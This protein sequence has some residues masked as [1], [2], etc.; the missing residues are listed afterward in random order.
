[1]ATPRVRGQLIGIDRQ[2]KKKTD[3]EKVRDELISLSL[4][5]VVSPA[6]LEQRLVDPSATSDDTDSGTGT[7]RDR[8]F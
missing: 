1:M 4:E 7:S 5:F 6:S 2:K 8:L 3:W